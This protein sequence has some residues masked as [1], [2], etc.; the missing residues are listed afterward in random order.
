MCRPPAPPPAGSSAARPS[1]RLAFAT[2]QLRPQKMDAPSS[3]VCG[4]G[5]VPVLGP[6]AER[7]AWCRGFGAQGQARHLGSSAAAAAAPCCIPRCRRRSSPGR[8]AARPRRARPPRRTRSC[9][10]CEG[11][12][13]PGRTAGPRR[14]GGDR[15]P[16]RLRGEMGPA[17]AGGTQRKPRPRHRRRWPPGAVAWGPRR[18]L[19]TSAGAAALRSG[20]R[21]G[22]GP[23]RQRLSACAW[24]SALRGWETCAS[25]RQVA[26]EAMEA[27]QKAAPKQRKPVP[28]ACPRTCAR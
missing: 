23:S 1:S 13:Q 7:G 3:Y 26:L 9:R 17:C 12:A 15:L 24:G 18:A 5:G 22:A 11:A 16:T 14:S 2:Y 21:R 28:K 27:A 4:P 10:G 6:V 19:Y 8:T 25:N 20:A